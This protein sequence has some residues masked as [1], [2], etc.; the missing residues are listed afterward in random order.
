MFF[1]LVFLM[2]RCV[3][4][5]ELPAYSRGLVSIDQPRMV[6][7]SVPWPVWRAALAPDFTLMMPVSQ[8][9]QSAYTT[10]IPTI[11]RAHNAQYGA[12]TA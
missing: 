7:N 5:Y 6:H 1:L 12:G 4:V 11:P 9:S 8:L 2:V 10:P 3:R